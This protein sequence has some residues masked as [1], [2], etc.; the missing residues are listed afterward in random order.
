MNRKIVVL[1]Y[2][3]ETA[4]R[5]LIERGVPRGVEVLYLGRAAG[6]PV[7]ED[8]FVGPVELVEKAR[9][10]RV[11]VIARAPLGVVEGLFAL[12]IGEAYGALTL[13]EVALEGGVLESGFWRALGPE[14]TRG[15]RRVLRELPERVEGLEAVS[16]RLRLPRSRLSLVL[17]R[18]A[19][20]G[21]YDVVSRRPLVAVRTRAGGVAAAAAPGFALA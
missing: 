6:L 5:R 9:G 8:V 20:L 21:L 15:E 11:S 13:E 1:G 10:S 14:L 2:R 19:G 18:L 3:P 16:A 7:E 4:A 17:R 12:A